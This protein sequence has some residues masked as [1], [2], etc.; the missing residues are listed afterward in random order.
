M[1]RYTLYIDDRKFEVE[2]GSIQGHQA[3]VTVNR[4]PYQVTIGADQP[5]PAP[6]VPEK[7][8]AA[9]APSR[10]VGPPS[11]SNG[12]V[13]APIPGIIVSIYVKAGDAVTAG[14][15][16]AVMEAMKMENNILCPKDGTIKE[17]RVSTGKDVATGEV[18]MTIA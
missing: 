4:R 9:P 3:Q 16:L 14:Q 1:T 13:T 17:I 6:P 8:A 18:L 10:T 11:G 5:A 12:L 7:P 2:I 15:V